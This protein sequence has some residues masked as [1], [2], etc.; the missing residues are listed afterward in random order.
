MIFEVLLRKGDLVEKFVAFSNKPRLLQRFK[1]RLID[2]RRFWE[3]VQVSVTG[4]TVVRDW[5][6]KGGSRS[7]LR[8]ATKCYVGS[9]LSAE[10]HINST[11][12]FLSSRTV[13][14]KNM[15]LKS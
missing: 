1:E 13:F 6:G 9:A 4:A 15:N 2:Y 11:Y 3:G 12:L 8:T 5:G 10:T 14:K 7:C